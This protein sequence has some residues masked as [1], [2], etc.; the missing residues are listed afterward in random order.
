MWVVFF[1]IIGHMTEAH[2]QAHRQRKFK[3]SLCAGLAMLGA[4]CA[5]D[6]ARAQAPTVRGTMSGEIDLDLRARVAAIGSSGA[7]LHATTLRLG[8]ELA[9]GIRVHAYGAHRYGFFAAQEAVVEKEW[10]GNAGHAQVGLVRLPFG[11][12]DPR[13]TYASGLIDYPMPRG[14]FYFH[15]LDWGVPGAAWS[16]G[17]PN[18]QVEAAGF[19]GQGTGIWDNQ[20]HIHGGAARAQTYFGDVILGLSRWDGGLQDVPTSSATHPVHMT[21]LD[22]RYTKTQLLVRGEYLFGTLAGDHTHGWYV[23]AYY[24]LP[25]HEHWSLVGR[26]ERL[27]PDDEYAES[28]QLT[29]GVR[30]VASQEWTLAAN[31]R[32]NNGLVY[33]PNWIPSAPKG[34]DVLL[35]AYRR[36]S[37]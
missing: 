6:T 1:A 21:G 4:L 23:D 32:H 27:K 28:R 13:E 7:K 24:R 17:P 3:P 33:S 12:Y 16:G 30:W 8:M 14:D 34:G 25:Q 19:S 26:L 5:G 11:I 31:W 37:W 35:Q 22:L 36:L 10:G 20:A 2:K 15:S 18:V 29:L 9:P